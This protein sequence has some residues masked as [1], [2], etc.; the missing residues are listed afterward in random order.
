MNR[1]SFLKLAALGGAGL[2]APT[3]KYVFDWRI[4]VPPSLMLH[5][6]NIQYLPDLLP[7]L[8]ED[9][10]PFTYRDWIEKLAGIRRYS[11][12]LAELFGVEEQAVHQLLSVENGDKLPL[13]L[14]IDDVGT[15]WIRSEHLRIFEILQQQGM[16]AVVGVQPKAMPAQ[17]VRYW[18][19]IKELHSAGWEIASHSINHPPLTQVN[20][21]TARYEIFESCDRIEQV[22]GARPIT[23]ITPFGDSRPPQATDQG[24]QQLYQLVIEAGLGV[25]AGIEGGRQRLAPQARE[26][27]RDRLAAAELPEYVGRI[28]PVSDTEATRWNL[29]HFNGAGYAAAA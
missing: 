13:I 14:S 8:A 12:W 23:L 15:D 17:E 28:P 29:L 26:Q 20:Q 24:N 1:R 25:V 18:D 9:F 11:I 19:I 5:S 27:V 2:F 16:R 3:K 22:I 4:D 21:Q 7:A 10:T 6:A